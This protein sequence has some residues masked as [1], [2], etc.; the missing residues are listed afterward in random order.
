MNARDLALFFMSFP[1]QHKNRL[2]KA[3]SNAF[4]LLFIPNKGT[5][6]HRKR[7]WMAACLLQRSRWRANLNRIGSRKLNSFSRANAVVFLCL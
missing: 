7:K 2:L 1:G 4:G 3:I 6:A 5:C